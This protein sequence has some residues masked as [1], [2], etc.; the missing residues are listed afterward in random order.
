MLNQDAITSKVNKNH[1]KNNLKLHKSDPDSL[2][3][4]SRKAAFQVHWMFYSFWTTVK[5]SAVEMSGSKTNT[6]ATANWR[7]RNVLTATWSTTKKKHE[8][9]QSTSYKHQSCTCLQKSEYKDK[10]TYLPSTSAANKSTACTT[11]RHYLYQINH[12][13]SFYTHLGVLMHLQ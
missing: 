8:T 4:F 6:T 12:S 11:W 5:Q 2:Q 1:F 3:H 7:I 9:I 13:T 10:W